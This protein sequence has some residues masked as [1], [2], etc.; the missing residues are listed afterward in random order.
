MNPPLPQDGNPITVNK[1]HTI[2]IHTVVSH[3]SVLAWYSPS[4]T[5]DVGSPVERRNTYLP[6]T[7]FT[8][9]FC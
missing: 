2:S 7:D 9:L 5:G 6:N 8:D 3:V 4:E 1:N